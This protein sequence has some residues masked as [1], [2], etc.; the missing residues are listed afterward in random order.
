M[1]KNAKAEIRS[2]PGG[3][4]TQNH[5]EYQQNSEFSGKSPPRS[6]C[7]RRANWG[8]KTVPGDSVHRSIQTQRE[9]I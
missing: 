7:I 8:P 6:V 3:D 2:P 4:S 1:G 9:K 5:S